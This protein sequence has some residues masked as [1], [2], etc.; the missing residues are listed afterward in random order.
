MSPTGVPCSSTGWT[1]NSLVPSRPLALRSA[2]TVPLTMPRYIA[3]QPSTQYHGGVRAHRLVAA[4]VLVGGCS[5]QLFPL[6]GDAGPGDV[7]DAV[8]APPDV[9]I[10]AP[11]PTCFGL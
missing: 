5:F 1:S 11:P 8:D 4:A 10:D 6:A 3:P 9:A 7:I 2:T